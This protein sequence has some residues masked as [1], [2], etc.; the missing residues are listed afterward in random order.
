MLRKLLVLAAAA[1]LPATVSQASY[2]AGDW[3]LNLSGSGFNGPDFDAA[4]FSVNAQL[5][6]M[7]SKPVELGVRQTMSFTDIGPGSNMAGST[8]VFADYHFFLGDKGEWV[9]FVGA[10]IGYVYGDAVSDTW[11]GA[12]EAGIK[13]FVNNTTYIS[14]MVEYQFFFDSNS[15]ASS[16]LSDG[17]FVY[18]LGMG[19]RL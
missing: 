1:L 18:T 12:P 14:L 17:Q 4:T 9:P 2:E 15:T 3:D 7:L 10:N 19:V 13:Y 6:Y 8:R 5:G 11:E 16:A